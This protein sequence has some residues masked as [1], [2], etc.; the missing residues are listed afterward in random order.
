[1]E[2]S[3]LKGN[4]FDLLSG[5][6]KLGVKPCSSPMVPGLYELLEKAKHLRILRDIEE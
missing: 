3:Y 4:V 2:S 6:G 5:I 1:M